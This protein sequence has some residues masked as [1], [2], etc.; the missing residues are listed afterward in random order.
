MKTPPRVIVLASLLLAGCATAP[1]QPR[2]AIMPAPNKPFE[3]FNQ[4]A[5]ICRSYAD[6][7]VGG[8][9]AQDV[10]TRD[11]ATGAVV[12]TLLGAATGT[13]ATAGHG[14]EG[15]GVGA[16]IGAAGGTAIGAANAQQ[17]QASLQQRYDLAYAQCMYSRG[18]QVPGY[19]P[20]AAPPPPPPLPT[21]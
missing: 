7:A 5:A 9:A 8:P 16:A 6:Q 20:A 12:G 18:N 2:V 19:A 14:G 11:L 3:I 15:A 10:A 17:T 1:M 21:R 4:D 13:L